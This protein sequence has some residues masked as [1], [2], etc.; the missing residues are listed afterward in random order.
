MKQPPRTRLAVIGLVVTV[1]ALHHAGAEETAAVVVGQPRPT[2]PHTVELPGSFE[3][4]EE[5]LLF[6]KVTGYASKVFV[7]I[8]HRVSTGAPLVR[9]D[10]PEM[11]PAL[12]RSRADVLVAEAALEM[13]EAQVRRDRITHERL[14]EL[15]AREPLAVTQQDVDMAAADLQG[16][17]AEVRS[18]A[19][20]ISAE[21]AKLEELEAL[22][23][24]AV[25]RAPFKGVVAQRFVNPGA[26]VV[27][28][29]CHPI[30]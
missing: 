30:R 16:A 27:S 20:G 26:L 13:A 1:L 12:G 11:K 8:G 6:A 28:G 29:T 21:R 10:I 17:E 22:M 5:A 2:A 3:P 18:A 14:S 24:Y 9:L 15:Q 4:Y 19:A 7:D 25:I 23:A